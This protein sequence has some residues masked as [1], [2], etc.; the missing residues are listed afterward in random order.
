MTRARRSLILLVAVAALALGTLTRA[1]AWPAG[2]KAGVAVAASG[3]VLAASTT[4]AL[5]VVAAIQR[6]DQG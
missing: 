4:L 5:R 3:I 6:A 1:L 2:P